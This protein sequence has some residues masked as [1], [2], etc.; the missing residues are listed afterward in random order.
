MLIRFIFR[1]LTDLSLTSN[2]LAALPEEVGDLSQLTV[3]RVD[4][5]R[6]AAL[7]DSIGRL[8]HLEELQVIKAKRQQTL[9]GNKF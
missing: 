5:N 6:L 4:D 3:L 9:F 7:P 1:S 2:N 8:T